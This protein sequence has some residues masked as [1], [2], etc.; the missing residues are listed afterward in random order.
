[1]LLINCEVSPSLTWSSTKQSKNIW[2]N[3]WRKIYSFQN[4]EEKVN[5]N[6]LRYI[7][8][9]EGRIPKSFSYYQNLIVFFIKLGDGTVK[10]REILKN[11]IDFKSDLSKIKKKI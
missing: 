6:N 3:C 7:Y 2:W 4:L 10:P 1:M 5:P 8:K 11:Q 9:T